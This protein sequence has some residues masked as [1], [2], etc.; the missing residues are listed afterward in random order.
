MTALPPTLVTRLAN[1]APA[2]LYDLHICITRHSGPT[3]TLQ[4]ERS[5]S[6]G[7]REQEPL[8]ILRQIMIQS[9]IAVVLAAH[10]PLMSGVDVHTASGGYMSKDGV[11]EEKI[12]T[13]MPPFDR[14]HSHTHALIRHIGIR[15]HLQLDSRFPQIK[16]SI[17]DD[18]QARMAIYR[19]YPSPHYA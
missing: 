8:P 17:L 19:E 13:K 18:P 3:S 2:A 12:W 14:V 11:A 7:K 9:H 5:R 15:I 1:S 4:T 6:P 16:Q 10:S